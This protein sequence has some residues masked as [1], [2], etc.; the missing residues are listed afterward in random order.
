MD[1][2]AVTTGPVTVPLVLSLGIGIAN[3]AGK[4]NSAFGLRRCYLKFP[5]S[6]IS[7]PNI[8]SFCFFYS[9]AGTNW[10]L[11]QLVPVVDADRA[12]SGSRRH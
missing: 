1:C 9:N 5:V 7:C 2:G 6:H 10:L 8:I 4:G 11:P 12:T 3:A